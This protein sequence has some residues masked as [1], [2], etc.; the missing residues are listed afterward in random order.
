MPKKNEEYPEIVPAPSSRVLL[1]GMVDDRPPIN[2]V[3]QEYPSIVPAPKA[4]DRS[5]PT[6]HEPSMA[7][8]Q[9]YPEI[10]E[11]PRAVEDDRRV[12]C[13]HCGGSL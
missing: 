7:P 1:P 6:R 8:D 2:A 3:D 11:A 5:E 12:V 10:V 13:P 4:E 9:T